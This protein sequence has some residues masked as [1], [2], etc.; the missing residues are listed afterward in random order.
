[1]QLE[2]TLPP[3]RARRHDPATS[4]AA[5]ER[6]SR[7]SESHAGRI[8]VAL[9]AGPQTAHELARRLGMSIE[10]VCRRLPDLQRAGMAVVAVC[11]GR[12]VTRDGFRVWQA[13]FFAPGQSAPE[14]VLGTPSSAFEAVGVCPPAHVTDVGRGA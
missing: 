11:D 3:P 10:Q 14:Q 5:A 8:H 6:A 13:S 4:H 12:V 7:F 2:L 1:M 9:M